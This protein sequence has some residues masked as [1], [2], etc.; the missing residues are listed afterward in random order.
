M[1]DI[2]KLFIGK[3]KQ[4]PHRTLDKD[5]LDGLLPCFELDVPGRV[6]FGPLVDFS[7]LCCGDWAAHKRQGETG[8]RD[9]KNRSSRRKRSSSWSDDDEGSEGPKMEAELQVRMARVAYKARMDAKKLT[10]EFKSYDKGKDGSVTVKDFKRVLE[11]AL[12]LSTEDLSKS[13]LKGLVKR[14]DP[15]DNDQIDYAIF[16]NWLTVE[17]QLP[18][19]EKRVGRCLQALQDRGTDLAR[20]TFRIQDRDKRGTITR[21]AFKEALDVLQLPVC[22]FEM[23]AITRKFTDQDTNEVN[24]REFLRLVRLAPGGGNLGAE[25][26]FEDHDALITRNAR[27]VMYEWY[28]KKD[29]GKWRQ[30]R[31]LFQQQDKDKNGKVT[32]RSF[33]KVLGRVKLKLSKDD[34]KNLTLCLDLDDDGAVYYEIFVDMV[35]NEPERPGDEL[36]AMHKRVTAQLREQRYSGREAGR[37]I[38][39]AFRRQDPDESGKVTNIQFKRACVD[40]LGLTISPMDMS[41]ICE[42]FDLDGRGT[43]VDYESFAKWATA[44]AD[45]D[46]VERKVGAGLRVIK[47]VGRS[48]RRAFEKREE[49]KISGI[50]TN[51]NFEDAVNALGLAVSEG[52]VRALSSK[53]QDRLDRINWK[54]ML[55]WRAPQFEFHPATANA[56]ATAA[57]PFAESLTLPT[58]PIPPTADVVAACKHAAKSMKRGGLGRSGLNGDYD[59]DDVDPNDVTALARRLREGIR[60]W[61]DQHPGELPGLF[62][63]LDLDGRSG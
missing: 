17:D 30:L 19:V 31:T 11:Q 54:G 55:R 56:T 25:A 45:I 59:G 21:A 60:D 53:Y 46:L 62:Y 13:E 8:V 49:A 37:D 41:S 16:V 32:P 27:H 38:A 23:L 22:D 57:Q 51:T 36:G 5:D 58:P 18:A 14:F 9:T 26:K 28:R 44:G 47:T 52:E 40:R 4:G 6:L 39:N 10:D 15:C 63:R 3:L 2:R 1:R 29:K 42:R 7:I 20:R 34:L 61:A 48:Y 35:M 50:I 24:Y 43:F 12:D 33:E